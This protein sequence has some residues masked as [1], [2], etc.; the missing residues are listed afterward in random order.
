MKKWDTPY[1][2]TLT[3][4][5]VKRYK[6][7]E[8]IENNHKIFLRIRDRLNKRAKR[9]K[10]PKL[11]A[12]RTSECN[13]NPITKRYNPHYHIIVPNREIGRLLNVEW[14]R[15]QNKNQVE[16]IARPSGQ[17]LTKIRDKKKNLK[18]VIKYG[19]KI[20][21]DPD[22]KKGK[23][24]TKLPI[25]YAAALHEI[26]KAFK[27]KNLLSTYGFTLPK[28]SAETNKRNV[29]DS[30]IKCW[31]YVSK[32]INFIEIDSAEVMYIKKQLPT[33][34]LQYI[35]NKRIDFKHY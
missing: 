33:A 2:L 35:M 22:M 15:E 32:S 1:F 7:K 10:G 25:I 18:E 28:V 24:R 30:Q 5:T 20:K 9:G 4:K 3:R 12:L 26:N 16:K 17:K 21:T 14:L 23:H 19:V 29:P 31:S 6:L 11:I 13:Y 27:G 34:E 8:T